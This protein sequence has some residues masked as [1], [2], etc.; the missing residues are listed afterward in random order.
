MFTAFLPSV[1]YPFLLEW[2]DK[3]YIT[4][5]PEMEPSWP[6]AMH[7]LSHVTVGVLTPV[8]MWSFMLDRWLFG[9]NPTA[10]HISNQL[11]HSLEAL[12]LFGLARRLGTSCWLAAVLA[13]LW[14]IHPQRV[15]SVVWLSERKDLLAGVF[16]FGA[17]LLFMRSFDKGRIPWGACVMLLLAM[18]SKPSTV[19]L[20]GIMA[21]YA[22]WRRPAIASLK[23]LAPIFLVSAAYY[24]YFLYFSGSAVHAPSEQFPRN[25]LLPLFNAS[26]YLFTGFIPF[27]LCPIHPRFW[28]SS[29][30]AIII[31]AG[32]ASLVCVA[33]V[34][35]RTRMT[36]REIIFRILPFAAA[37][38]CLFLP[39]SS[40]RRFIYTDYCDRYNYL[41][42]AV[43]WLALGA[44]LERWLKDA[45]RRRHAAI[46]GAMAALAYLMLTLAYMPFWQDT[47]VL[48]VHCLEQAYPSPKAAISLGVVGVNRKDAAALGLAGNAL[49]RLSAE[50]INIQLPDD[51][52]DT[53]SERDTGLLLTG[54]AFLYEGDMDAATKTLAAVDDACRENRLS[55][56][57]SEIFA[58][59]LWSALAEFHLWGGRPSDA[60]RCLRM[61]LPLL[62]PGTTD[63][64]FC[65]GM[66]AYLDKD[67]QTARDKWLKAEKLSPGDVNIQH[68]LRQLD[69][70]PRSGET[71]Q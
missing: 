12:L 9:L 66:I 39:V 68:N 36:S 61:K 65:E 11:I 50:S 1:N 49:L 30:S 10:F 6:N 34:V 31:L 33:V 53:E 48:F 47:K 59:H 56:F 8:T 16:G 67:F 25:I 7:W 15:E 20:P 29:F 32:I 3:D 69:E 24:L 51:L 64:F 58:P 19:T 62:K 5:A 18:G 26:W 54:L 46:A 14:G 42:S 71:T 28:L 52:K 27:D 13:I 22:L 60:V 2:D 21:I 38:L 41:L 44:L 37:W 57:E 63:A 40:L 43:A 70:P 17:A 35:W 45:K 55:I 23:P 4:G